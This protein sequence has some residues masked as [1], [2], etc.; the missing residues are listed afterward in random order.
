VDGKW[1][2]SYVASVQ[3]F[4]DQLDNSF[5]LGSLF[6]THV[7]PV[8]YSRTRHKRGLTPYAFRITSALA[9]EQPTWLRRRLTTP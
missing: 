7:N 8:V 6:P 5:D 1:D 2:P 4:A 9:N 3:G